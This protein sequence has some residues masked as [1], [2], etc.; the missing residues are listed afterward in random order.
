MLAVAVWSVMIVVCTVLFLLLSC[1]VLIYHL[2]ELALM[3]SD[4]VLGHLY[5]R[6]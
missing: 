3:I 4:I 2:N 6:S 1:V 5:G